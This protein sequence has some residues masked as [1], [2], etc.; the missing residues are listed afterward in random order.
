[1]LVINFAGSDRSGKTEI[2]KALAE[3][4]GISYFKNEQEIVNF[5]S[6]KAYFRNVLRY[7]CPI[8]ID[9]IKQTKTHA[10]FDRN[11][12]CEWVYSRALDRE[13]YPEDLRWLD[14]AY[15]DLGAVTIVCARKSYDGI[16]DDAF[17]DD[18][19]S[20]KLTEINQLYKSFCEWSNCDSFVVYVD[21]EDLDREISD[22]MEYLHTLL[23]E[24]SHAMV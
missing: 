14:N 22:I 24:R 3:R 8:L 19:N 5:K 20:K 16:S 6:D 2:A 9:F 15:A 4:L 11:Y 21:D 10:I 18:L 17:P 7:G 13:T 1:M 23:K 12:A